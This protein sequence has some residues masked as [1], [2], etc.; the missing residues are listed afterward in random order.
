MRCPWC[1][2]PRATDDIDPELLCRV[3]EAEWDGLSLSEL[4]RRDREESA[5]YNEWVLGH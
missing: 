3:H 5:E 2:N 4:D 1:L